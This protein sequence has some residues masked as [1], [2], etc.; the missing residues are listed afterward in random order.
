MDTKLTQNCQSHPGIFIRQNVIPKNLTVTKAA[1]LLGV[2]RVA[3]SNLLNGKSSLSQEMALRLE[4]V[5]G[6]NRTDLLDLQSQYTRETETSQSLVTTGSFSPPIS[7]I[8]AKDIENWASDPNS[9][10]TLAAL[11][12]RL[13]S[14][15]TNDLVL[16]D[17][18]A[19]ENAERPG[20][21]GLLES[22]SRT[23]WV[24]SGKSGWELG[25][26]IEPQ[27]KAESDYVK[28]KESV[29]PSKAREITFIFVT[30][31][32]WKNKNSW[33]E[34]KRESNYWK[35]VRCYDASD[36]EQWVEQSAP[37]QIWF[38]E[39]IG[40]TVN[41]LMSLDQ[42]W[43]RWSEVCEKGFPKKMFE[44]SIKKHSEKIQQWLDAPPT[45]KLVIAADSEQEALAF[46][47]CLFEG[48]PARLNEPGA[49]VVVFDSPEG[50]ERF[51]LTKSSPRISVIY[52]KEV[53]REV[54]GLFRSSHCIV[55]CTSND[56]NYEPDIELN[57]PGRSDFKVALKELNYCDAEIQQLAR[58][59]AR[60]PTILRRILSTPGETRASPWS[61]DHETVQILIPAALVGIWNTKNKADCAAVCRLFDT[62][63]YEEI[64]RYNSQLLNLDETPVWSNGDYHGVNS[65]V[66][67]LFGIAKF[68]TNHDLE[69][70]FDVAK[71]VLSETDPALELAECDRW[72][73]VL[74]Q[75]SMQ[76]S[77]ALRR[78]ICETLIL[79][80]VFGKD[81]FDKRLGVVTESRVSK[82]I[83]FLLHPNDNNVLISQ[84]P[85]FPSY[86]EAAPDTFLSFIENDLSRCDPTLR[87]FMRPADGF[88]LKSPNRTHLL[89]ALECLA[90]NSSHFPR[91][92]K[93]LT[94][95]C[96]MQQVSG[97]DSWRN[98]PENTLSSLFHPWVP[99]TATSV[100]NRVRTLKTVCSEN[101]TLGWNLCVLGLDPRRQTVTENFHPRWREDALIVRS[102]P[103]DVECG[104]GVYFQFEG[105]R[106]QM[107]KL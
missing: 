6:T 18:P 17:F 29:P 10:F 74:F 80:S 67:A 86:A 28:R 88:L 13:V 36:L 5:F 58:K 65:R 96:E 40:I 55:L 53:E 11:I 76:H 92:V 7:L 93:I 82:L 41:G 31:R 62:K 84:M 42:C 97:H 107:A 87:E 24:P 72:A 21:D 1:K 43:S 66:V 81:L 79:L 16:I 23:S 35:D 46:L 12:R 70:F 54:G 60:S 14:T 77:D 50:I 22:E 90:W 102:T 2:S 73:A 101:P 4:R 33:V 52:K 85:N 48:L 39:Q 37:T 89:W 99:M 106:A 94:K 104:Q 8:K 25:C 57:I 45:E 49:S 20:W 64:E 9:R 44:G 3:L 68:V 26:S 56:L 75:K 51:T 19:Y 15:T 78:G 61:D 59:S 91:V 95:L 105:D 34:R 83:K 63:R 71:T 98:S 27:K 32:N 47:C 38:A 100:E 69:S 30:P 103:F